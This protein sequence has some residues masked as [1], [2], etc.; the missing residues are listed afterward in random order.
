M[1]IRDSTKYVVTIVGKTWDFH[2][3][4]VLRVTLEENLE[5]IFETVKYFT[6]RGRT[7]IYDCEHF[8][9]GF[10]ANAEYAA[11]TICA[12]A[13]GGSPRRAAP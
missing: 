2:A 3:T 9:D 6:D 11:K 4:E 7:V 5:M 8:F 13:T 1:C 10:K 12:A